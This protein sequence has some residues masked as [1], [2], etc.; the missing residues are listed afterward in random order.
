MTDKSTPLTAD[1]R[2]GIGV[3]IPQGAVWQFVGTLLI[4]V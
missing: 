2:E 3:Q 4:A 1:E